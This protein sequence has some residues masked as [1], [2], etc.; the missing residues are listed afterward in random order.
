MITRRDFCRNSALA[1]AA[2]ASVETLSST[3]AAAGTS[4]P[5]KA[6]NSAGLFILGLNTSTLRGHKLPITQ[7]I[8]IAAECGYE[9][10]EPWPDELDRHVE[11]GGT[12]KDLRKQLDD[13]GLRVTGAIAFYEWMVN[14]DQRR[15]RALE[16]AKRRM[17]QVGQIGGT[18]IA[19]PPAGDVAN[20][21]LLAAAERYRD[22]L[23]TADRMGTGVIPALEVW[24]RA[25]RL[26]RLGEVVYVALE[27]QH[28]KACILPDVFHLYAGGS[29]LDGIALLNPRL[30]AGFHLNDYPADPPRDKIADRDRIYPGDGIA[31]LSKLLRDL[32]EIGYSGALS[33]ELFNPQ[34]YQQDPTDVARTAMEKTR[35]LLQKLA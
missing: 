7:T 16:E 12:L 19:A 27:A 30:L 21:E 34:Y 24:G 31:P 2:A 8:R 25:A 1:L 15:A 33:I 5:L 11:S 23:E 9:A 29:D 4:E 22:L 17:D 6:R 20:V 28:P 14:D 3:A 10:I 32:R 35:A 13:L 18:H 26:S